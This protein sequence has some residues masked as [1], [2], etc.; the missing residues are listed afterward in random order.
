[1]RKYLLLGVVAT[2]AALGQQPAFEV[3]SIRSAAQ[4][5]PE[6]DRSQASCI[7]A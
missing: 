6:H 5:T 3:A 7:S 4:I 1:M 2:I